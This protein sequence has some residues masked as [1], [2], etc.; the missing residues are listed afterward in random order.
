MR[1][2]GVPPHMGL[3]WPMTGGRSRHWQALVSRTH[4]MTR[5]AA[6]AKPMKFADTLWPTSDHVAVWPLCC[7]AEFLRGVVLLTTCSALRNAPWFNAHCSDCKPGGRVRCHLSHTH[8]HT[9]AQ[10][11]YAALLLAAPQHRITPL[12]SPSASMP[13]RQHGLALRTP[14]LHEAKQATKAAVVAQKHHTQ[15]AGFSLHRQCT[16]HTAACRHAPLPNTTQCHTVCAASA[17]S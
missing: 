1:R 17:Q 7:Y 9:Q 12:A 11:C 3:V 16:R 2:H 5:H 14:T 6:G 13:P 10:C 8:T 4:E 15:T